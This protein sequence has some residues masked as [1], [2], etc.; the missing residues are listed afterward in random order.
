M[1]PSWRTSDELCYAVGKPN[2]KE[3][4]RPAE[5]YLWRP[6]AEARCISKEWPDVVVEALKQN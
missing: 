4:N 1:V 6:G 5:V 3:G 2:G